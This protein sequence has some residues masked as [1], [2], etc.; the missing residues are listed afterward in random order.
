MCSQCFAASWD[1]DLDDDG[2]PESLR[3]LFGTSRRWLENGKTIQ[4]DRAP[5]A[6]GPVSVL[7]RSEIEAGRVVVELKLP[8]R[9]R[10]KSI[11]LRVRIPAGFRVDSAAIGDYIRPVDANGTIDLT[12]IEG[13]VT[14][15]VQV[16]PL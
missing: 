3:L 16:R 12:E 13:H 2:Q 1:W 5:T 4:I 8:T 14:V 10:P 11:Q 15:L 6:F 7:A 9:N